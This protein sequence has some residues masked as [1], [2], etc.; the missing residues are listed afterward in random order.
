MF[1][2]NLESLRVGVPV[3][4]PRV[5]TDYCGWRAQAVPHW[6]GLRSRCLGKGSFLEHFYGPWLPCYVCAVRAP[7]P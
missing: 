5:H 7:H 2:R 4:A 1:F 3:S 6:G